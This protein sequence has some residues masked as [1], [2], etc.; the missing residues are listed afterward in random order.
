[1]TRNY[2]SESYSHI[3]TKLG[4]KDYD[5]LQPLFMHSMSYLYDEL[6]KANK[7][8]AYWKLSFKKQCEATK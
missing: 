8:V 5:P 4:L 1:M 7:Q 6:D 3:K 2:I